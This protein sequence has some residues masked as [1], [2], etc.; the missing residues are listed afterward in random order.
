MEPVNKHLSL[1][2]VNFKSYFALCHQIENRFSKFLFNS[3]EDKCIQ[4][5]VEL[6]FFYYK[7]MSLMY[8]TPTHLRQHEYCD[9]FENYQV[10]K[11]N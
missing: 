2:N 10:E 11:Y 5:H 8:D 9:Y 6:F 1:Q 4:S 3:D 7:I